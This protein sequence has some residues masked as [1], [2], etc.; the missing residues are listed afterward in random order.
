M[1]TMENFILALIVGLVMVILMMLYRVIVG[2]TVYDRF[3]GLLVLGSDVI[4]LIILVGVYFGRVEMFVDIS[5]TF[6]I[7]GFISWVILG[8]YIGE[9]I[10]GKKGDV[11]G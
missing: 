2:P 8:K 1:L 9:S 3:N 7:L 4:I 10:Q 5:L 11:D 6:A